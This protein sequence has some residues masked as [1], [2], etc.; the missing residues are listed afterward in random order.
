MSDEEKA[1]FVADGRERLLKVVRRDI[2][3][4]IRER[5]APELESAGLFQRTLIEARIREEIRT[6]LLKAAPPEALY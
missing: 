5:H 3:R 2:V 6:A 1:G 4:Q